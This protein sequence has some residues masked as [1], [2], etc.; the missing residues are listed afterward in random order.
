MLWILQT[1]F[2][3]ETGYVTLVDTLNSL[4]LKHFVVKVVPGTDILLPAETDTSRSTKDV[5][6]M[7]HVEV[8]ASEPVIAMGSYT[9]AKIAKARGW[10]PGSFTDNT[11]YEVWSKAWG[12][13]RLLNPRARVVTFG[14]ADFD[15]EMAFIRP[16]EDSKAFPGNVFD[17]E[18][19]LHWKETVLKVTEASGPL[20]KDTVVMISPP[21]VIYTETRLF[22]VDG[23]VVTASVYKRGNRVVYDA[24]FDEDIV[25]YGQECV[26]VWQPN[27]AFVLDIAQTPD[28]PKI[29]EVNCLNSAGYYACD[30][31]KI[32]IAL[33][34]MNDRRLLREA[35]RDGV[36]EGLGPL[37]EIAGRLRDIAEKTIATTE[38][39]KARLERMKATDRSS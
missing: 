30:V 29:V 11:S 25:A 18:E 16:V 34:E 8:D 5:E 31:T 24:T 17:R 4:G 2:Y 35:I 32:V 9:L 36:R 23:K 38:I 1:N 14:E 39:L 28:G 12:P 20:N 33:E 13:E 27:E 19:F 7:E 10:T 21:R 15:G 26:D 6:D 3:R 37:E 22:V